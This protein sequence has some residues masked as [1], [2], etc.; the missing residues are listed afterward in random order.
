MIALIF[1]TW[2]FSQNIDLLDVDIKEVSGI[3]PRVL[4]LR[5]DLLGIGVKHTELLCW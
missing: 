4:S 5:M 3:M 1:F 2:A